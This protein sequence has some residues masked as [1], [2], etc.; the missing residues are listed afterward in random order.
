[1]R[2]PEFWYDSSSPLVRLLLPLSWLWRLATWLRWRIARPYQ[3]A[4]PTF[5]IGN[6]TVGGVG[7]TP[8]VQ[9]FARLAIKA[10]YA[11]VI[12]SRGYGGRHRGV[13]EVTPHHQVR[14]V[15]DEALELRAICP[16]VVARKRQDALR[17]IERENLGD[18]II[19]DDGFQNPHLKPHH[20]ILVFDGARGIGNGQIIPSGPM[21][22]PMAA[23]LKRAQ[24]VLIIGTDRHQLAK[25]IT[26]LAPHIRIHYAE[27]TYDAVTC[28]RIKSSGK[29]AVF[30]G[31]G[32]AEGFFNSVAAH[33][34]DVVARM[35]FG[36]HHHYT[37]A[38]WARIIAT[39]KEHKA[40][41]I[42]TE[43]DYM[44]LNAEQRRKVIPLPLRLVLSDTAWVME[45][46][47]GGQ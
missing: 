4:L 39:A 47:A 17:H 42:T 27:K 14:L 28:R 30:A 43:K 34:G 33:G 29:L 40:T 15:G 11:P 13:V 16:V 5:L 25:R 46:L 20:A 18:C 6:L 21:R 45:L 3:S 26:A 38:D 41:L 10:G 9:Q 12:I 36:D 19:M 32:N 1:M 31:L 35:D 44:R 24:D 7:K 37:D 22:E 23:G 8:L 2:A